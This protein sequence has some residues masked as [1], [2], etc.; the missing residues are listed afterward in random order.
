MLLLFCGS[1]DEISS[2][3]QWSSVVVDLYRIFIVVSF[4]F[5]LLKTLEMDLVFIKNYYL[6]ALGWMFGFIQTESLTVKVEN[7]NNL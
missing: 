2:G 3:L 4:C 5:L 6:E 7:S 1:V